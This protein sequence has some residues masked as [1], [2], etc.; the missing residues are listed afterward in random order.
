MMKKL[1]PSILLLHL[2]LLTVFTALVV[3]VHLIPRAAIEPQFQ[4]SVKIF[5]Q[6]GVYPSKTSLDGSVLVDNFTDCYMLNVAYCADATHPVDAAMRNYRYRDDANMVITMNHLAS[7]DLTVEMTEYGKYWHG[8]QVFLRPLLAVMDYGKIRVVN[9]IMLVILLLTAL[10][11]MARRL[12]LG[13]P[14]C[15]VVALFMVHSGVLPWSLQYSTCYYISLVSVIALLGFGW[16][17]GTWHRLLLC[18]FAIGAAT[19]F[20]DF[21]TTPVMTL[22]IPLTV[23]VLKDDRLC[24]MRA[25]VALCA[26]WFLGY[27]LMWGSKWVMAY[28]LAGYNPLEEVALFMQIHTVGQGG[29]PVGAYG[30]KMLDLLLSRW[31]LLSANGLMRWGIIAALAIP[32]MVFPKGRSVLRK[33]SL[34]LFVAMLAPLWYVVVAHHSYSHFFITMR[35]L[36]VSWFSILCF[37]YQNIDFNKLTRHNNGG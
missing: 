17:S 27:S 8:Y 3:V 13:I 4:R 34:L 21:F 24:R 35:A 36:L 14:I 28:L 5:T 18:F 16:L 20:L 7:G 23:M 15:F 29:E 9:G 10:T 33:Y 1:I 37:L 12:S 30:K 25:V 31:S 26:T 32:A 22:G 6:E 19:S 11:L 2:V